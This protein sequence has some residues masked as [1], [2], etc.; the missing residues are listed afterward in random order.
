VRK[1]LSASLP[2]L[3]MAAFSAAAVEP[4]LISVEPCKFTAGGGSIDAECGWIAVPETHFA[5]TDVEIQLP[6]VR[7]E[8]TSAT[9]GAPIVYLA[10]GPGGSGI[11][12]AKS[13]RYALFMKLREAADVIALDQRGTGDAKPDLTYNERM[14]FPLDQPAD[15]AAWKPL[16][17]KKFAECAQHF[18]EKN[19]HLE[20]Y[21]TKESAADVDALRRVLG[22]EK[23]SLWGTSYG[24]HL[25][26][27][28]VRYFGTH[29]DR[30]VLAGAEGPDHTFKLPSTTDEH[31]EQLSEELAKRP[32]IAEKIPDLLALTKRLLD[33][34]AKEPARVSMQGDTLAI[35]PLDLQM[36]I[37]ESVGRRRTIRPLPAALYF[38]DQGNFGRIAPFIFTI[39]RQPIGNAMSMAMDCASGGSQER[40]ARLQQ[41]GPDALLGNTSNFPFEDACSALGVPDLGDEFRAPLQSDV[42][43]LF[44]SGTLDARTP[45]ANAEEV[46]KGFTTNYHIIVENAGHD[47][48]LFSLAPGLGD[49][50]VTFFQGGTPS[51]DRIAYDALEIGPIQ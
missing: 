27:A 23:I 8:S 7:F 14:A 28:V 10:G 50:M 11:G 47:E 43:A 26:C 19:I 20:H 2:I 24:T 31:Y 46:R 13:R 34:L 51:E 40:R 41:E 21:N 15:F 12:T 22:L 18:R 36:Y 6:Y 4:R 44:I 3:A 32:E 9:P 17:E 5:E 29:I 38:A 37:A 42:P 35:G 30:V 39:R 48:E 1:T 45:I 16:V 49:R 25:S 33:R